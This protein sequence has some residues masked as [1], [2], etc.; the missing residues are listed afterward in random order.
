M[1]YKKK[2]VLMSYFQIVFD[3]DLQTNKVKMKKKLTK[4]NIL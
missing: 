4:T 3:L 1:L 2:C